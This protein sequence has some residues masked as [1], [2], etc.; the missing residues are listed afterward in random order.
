MS[1]DT[2]S[3]LAVRGVRVNT[4]VR[5]PAG[6]GPSDDGHVVLD[7]RNAALPLNPHSPYSVADGRV[8]LGET[9]TGL[10]LDV[11]RRPHFYD[12]VTADG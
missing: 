10:T 5:R 11:V 12:L 2:H 3:D 8:W 1:L 4:P 6:A 9:D 7:G